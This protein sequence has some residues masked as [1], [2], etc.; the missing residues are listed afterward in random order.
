MKEIKGFVERTKDGVK[1]TIDL[2]GYP[3]MTCI[4]ELDKVVAELKKQGLEVNIIDKKDKPGPKQ[5]VTERID[6]EG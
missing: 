5:K 1:I 2:N 3:E 6:L 4:K